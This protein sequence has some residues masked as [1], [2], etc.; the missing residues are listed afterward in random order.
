MHVLTKEKN[1]LPHF[2]KKSGALIDNSLGFDWKI[3][4]KFIEV[5]VENNILY[6]SED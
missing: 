6:N 4:F 2:Q 1:N 5:S 3:S